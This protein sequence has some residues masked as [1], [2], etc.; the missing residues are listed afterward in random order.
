MLAFSAVGKPEARVVRRRMSRP[1]SAFATTPTIA[2]PKAPHLLAL[3]CAPYGKHGTGIAVRIPRPE[4]CPL[5][6]AAMPGGLTNC[7]GCQKAL[8][9]R[10]PPRRHAA[11]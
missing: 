3:C 4:P 1:D 5:L 7:H 10:V 2:S 6:R 8:A 9:G 11:T